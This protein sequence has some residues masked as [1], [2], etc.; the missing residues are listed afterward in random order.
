MFLP[1]AQRH[2]ITDR[3]DKFAGPNF[4]KKTEIWSSETPFPG[5][6]DYLLCFKADVFGVF[7]GPKECWSYIVLLCKR[8]QIPLRL[9]YCLATFRNWEILGKCWWITSYCNHSKECLSSKRSY[10]WQITA[11]QGSPE[12]RVCVLIGRRGEVGVGGEVV[13]ED[14]R[15]P[16]RGRGL[17]VDPSV[18]EAAWKWTG[19]VTK[20]CGVCGLLSLS[21][22][23]YVNLPCNRSLVSGII[24]IFYQWR[25][26]WHDPPLDLCAIVMTL[27][28]ILQE[29]RHRQF[30]VFMKTSTIIHF[31]SDNSEKVKNSQATLLC[32]NYMYTYSSKFCSKSKSRGASSTTVLLK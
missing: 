25:I 28:V 19:D 27:L 12:G 14:E 7:S 22:Y 5:H 32:E 3:R 30:S 18:E 17:A 29:R 21:K 8:K 15:G 16:L 2:L 10:N 13:W 1:L 26:G 31:R 9:L 24:S 4:L 23:V 6:P 20:Y 11:Q